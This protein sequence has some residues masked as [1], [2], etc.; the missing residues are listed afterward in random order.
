M[1]IISK[2]VR[3]TNWPWPLVWFG[4]NGFGLV[5]FDQIWFGLVGFILV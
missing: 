3:E 5:W 2:K 1:T 4:W